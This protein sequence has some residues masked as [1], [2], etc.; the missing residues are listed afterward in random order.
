LAR[1]PVLRRTVIRAAGVIGDGSY[2]PWLVGQTSEPSVAR[3]AGH[4]F[5]MITG[6]DLVQHELDREP[7]VE[8][9]A[10]PDD[11]PADADV[12]LDDDEG[13][14]W[15]DPGRVGRWW[16]GNKGRFSAGTGYFR[17]S[18]KASTNWVAALSE[19][20]QRQRWTAALELAVRRPGSAMFAVRGRGDLQQGLLRRA[21]RLNASSA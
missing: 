11:D 15:P 14:A 9:D 12:G 3:A 17:G 20:P 16:E 10:G 4:A 21:E 6:V 18:P 1:D 5:A 2:L 13:L 7:P 8:F 19:A